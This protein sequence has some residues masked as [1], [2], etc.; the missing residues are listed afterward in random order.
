MGNEMRLDTLVE[1]S[2]RQLWQ[3]KLSD[4]QI[5]AFERIAGEVNRSYGYV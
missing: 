5:N 3:Q 2:D 1:I 4:G